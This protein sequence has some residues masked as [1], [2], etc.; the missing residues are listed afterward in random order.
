V[1]RYSTAIVIAIAIALAAVIVVAS[2]RSQGVDDAQPDA[3]ASSLPAEHRGQGDAVSGVIDTGAAARG[4]AALERARKANPENLRV[5]LHLADAYRAARRYDDAARAYGDALA[6]SP[7]H[8]NATV[9]LAMVWYARG[10]D[11]RA[12]RLLERVLAAYPDHQ[13]AEFDLALVRFARQEVTAAKEAWVRATEIDPT[14][15]LG[16]ASQDFVDLLSDGDAGGAGL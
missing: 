14:S 2:S 5:M 9:G 3:A 11:A 1:R 15:E 8:P 10:D 16:R 6:A 4:I 13:Q 7:G 12:I